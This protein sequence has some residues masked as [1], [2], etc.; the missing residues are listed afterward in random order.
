MNHLPPSPW[1]TLVSFRFCS[2]IH[3][4][5]R[6][7]WCT[8][9]INDIGGKFA[10]G[11]NDTDGKVRHQYRS[12][13]WYQRY[14]RVSTT[15]VVNLPLVSMAPAVPA[16]KFVAGVVDTGG[17][18]CHWYWWGTLTCKYLREFSNKFDGMEYSGAW[19]KLIHEKNLTSK[20]SWHC[21]FKRTV[22][23]SLSE[24]TSELHSYSERL[25]CKSRSQINQLA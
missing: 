1:K 13:R 25:L 6:K 19:G 9:S 5:I 21:P 11:L 15:P 14:R 7:S 10:I 22:C 17:R 4:D 16:A 8:I 23:F 20:I 12:C 18:R 2:K 3:G 24:N